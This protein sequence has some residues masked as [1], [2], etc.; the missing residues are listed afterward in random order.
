[1]GIGTPIL[2]ASLWG[3]FAVPD[4]PSRSGKTLIKTPGMLRLILEIL[5]FL[6]GAFTLYSL[7]YTYLFYMY[8]AAVVLHHLLSIDRIKWLLN[9]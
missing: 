5:F 1:M 9:Q 2:M 3:I 7:D 4:D 8:S 6:F